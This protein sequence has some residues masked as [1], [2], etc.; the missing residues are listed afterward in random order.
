MRLKTLI[1]KG[2][3]ALLALSIS[4]SLV[5]AA[6]AAENPSGLEFDSSASE[7]AVTD[8]AIT[9]PDTVEVRVNIPSRQNRRQIIMNNYQNGSESSWGIEV[10]TDDTLR[11][12]E[13]V[14]GEE[15]SCKFNSG[16]NKIDVCTGDWMLISV[17]RDKTNNQVLAY[18][19]G[20][21]RGTMEATKS[22]H[23]AST[24]HE[25]YFGTDLRKG[26]FLNG[27]I[28]EVRMWS[29]ERTAEE[30][31]EYADKSVTGTEEELIHAWQFEQPEEKNPEETVF[32]DL[33]SDGVNVTTQG[34]K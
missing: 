17:V 5:P 13:R 30:I 6:L 28:G 33:V 26:Y 4:A 22:F 11:Y 8:S 31:A 32:E 21:L 2:V 29:D 14:N 7:Y 34:Y 24:T 15:I 16:E 10:N 3:S 9:I 23:N 19:N 1:K 25:L 27:Q 18:I 20:T 12:W